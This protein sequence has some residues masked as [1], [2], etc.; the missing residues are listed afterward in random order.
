MV[1]FEIPYIHVL[2]G[3]IDQHAYFGLVD[4]DGPWYF[5]G[6]KWDGILNFQML[7]SASTP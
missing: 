7:S 4:T 1:E 3:N 2:A 5:K 6:K